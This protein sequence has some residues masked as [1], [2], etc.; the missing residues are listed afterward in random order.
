MSLIKEI[1]NELLTEALQHSTVVENL[2]ACKNSVWLESTKI[3]TIIESA[4]STL[5][6][7]AYQAQAGKMNKLE[8]A[9]D[10]LTVLKVL[11]DPEYRDA[12][13]D[14]IT[15]KQFSVIVNHLGEDERITKFLKRHAMH[16]SFQKTKKE[17]QDVLLAINSGEGAQTASREIQKLRM[18]YERIQAKMSQIGKNG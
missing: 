18:S 9:I 3:E 12:F 15:K 7:L 16:P 6:S 2:N 14:E 8:D 17:I 5:S 4:V 10:V 13:S 1:N 11:Q